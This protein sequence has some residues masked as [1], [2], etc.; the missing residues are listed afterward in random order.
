MKQVI[1][2]KRPDPRENKKKIFR[3][4][5]SARHRNEEERL[6]KE[7]G[8]WF[9]PQILEAKD[10]DTITGHLQSWKYFQTDSSRL[11]EE[12]F[13]P[14]CPSSWF[15]QTHEKLSGAQ[16]WI[17]VHVRRGDYV[18]IPRMG[19]T[20]DYYYS[21]ALD[22]VSKLSGIQNVVVFSDNIEA[23]RGLPSLKNRAETYFLSPPT[24]S[25]PLENLLLL[26]LSNHLIGA[27]SSF[28]WWAGW[29]QNKEDRIVTYPRPWVDFRYIND[30]DLQ[31]PNWIGLGRETHDVAASNHLGY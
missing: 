27:N 14:I 3:K 4:F 30:R 8:F 2:D 31:L 23:A 13:N 11:R 9:D 26:S 24:G 18:D 20:T 25:S 10:G 7:R 28:S 5:F 21:R 15:L 17:G 6:I 29:L 19:I 16:P 22:I 12:I 1:N